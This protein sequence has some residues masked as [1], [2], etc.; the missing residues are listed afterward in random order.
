MQKPISIFS[1]LKYLRLKLLKNKENKKT[2]PYNL[3]NVYQKKSE[4]SLKRFYFALISDDGL[5]LKTW[6]MAWVRWR[7]SNLIILRDRRELIIRLDK[8]HYFTRGCKVSLRNRPRNC[9]NIKKH[10]SEYI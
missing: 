8:V 6:E 10:K 3:K 1:N 9:E 4:V 5:T 7:F 2:L